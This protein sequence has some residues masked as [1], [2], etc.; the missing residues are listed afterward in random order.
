M[1]SD[2]VLCGCFGL[3]PSYVAGILNSVKEIHFYVL[4]SKKLHYSEYI[5]KFIAGNKC[6]VSYTKHTDC[7]FLLFSGGDKT[8]LSFTARRFSEIPMELIFAQ[9]VLKRMRLSSL[10]YGI[11][12]IKKRVTYITNQ[13]LTSKHG[14]VFDLFDIN[15]H[16]PKRLANCTS[17]T[18]SCSKHPLCDFFSTSTLYCT[19]KAHR[20]F[21]QPQCRCKLFIKDSPAGLKSQCVNK[22][23]EF[24][25]YPISLRK[26]ISKFAC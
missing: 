12:C 6:S 8:A 17:F 24:T 22:I 14:C 11:V 16:L 5:E 19:K 2:K 1:N 23:S 26:R 21:K 9:S 20:V 10:V 15:L 4:C 3:Y 25:F 13:V 7:Y 18:Q